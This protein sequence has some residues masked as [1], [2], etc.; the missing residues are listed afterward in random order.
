MR[1]PALILLAAATIAASPSAASQTP[2]AIELARRIQAHYDTVRDFRADFTQSHK[3]PFLRQ[4][5]VERGTIVVKKVN[6]MRVT[7]TSRP[8]KEFVADGKTFYGHFIEDKLGTETPL[9][10]TGESSVA[11]LFLA[12][13]GNLLQDFTAAMPPAQPDGRWEL[14]LT[15][16]TPQPD[17]DTLTLVVERDTYKLA[18][19]STTDADSGTSTFEFSNLR[20]NTGVADSTFNFKFPPNVA[21]RK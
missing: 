1:F 3:G 12:G 19:L 15:P 6:R 18:G 9:P 8:K 5:S 16:K 21:I 2:S 11:L 13:R 7:Y 20:E 4:T 10:K 17:F 14:V